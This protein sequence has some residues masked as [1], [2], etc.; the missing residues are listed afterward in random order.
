MVNQLKLKLKLNFPTTLTLSTF[1]PHYA[2]FLTKNKK[3]KLPTHDSYKK[4]TTNSSNKKK[5]L[6][7]LRGFKELVIAFSTSKNTLNLINLF[8]FLKKRNKIKIV[9]GFKELIIAFSTSKN[10][11]NLINLFL[12]LKKRNKIKIVN[13]LKLKLKLNFPTT[14][15]LS[16]FQPHYATFLTKNKKEKLPTHGSYK[17]KKLL[18]IPIKKIK[19]K[20]L[21][22]NA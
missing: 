10:T 15:T 5:I 7:I 1:Q 20:N 4:K 9:R 3:E 2:T 21:L 17:K 22:T 14:L 12:F 8:L 6:Y 16:T 11:L 19:I 18:T 13:Q